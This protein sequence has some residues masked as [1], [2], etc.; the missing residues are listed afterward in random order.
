MTGKYR[1]EV[2][3][4]NTLSSLG[5]EAKSEISDLARLVSKSGK[6][7]TK[8]AQVKAVKRK[9]RGLRPAGEDGGRLQ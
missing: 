6:L 7:G 5:G 8:Q 2:W 3:L 9:F 4:N 1:G